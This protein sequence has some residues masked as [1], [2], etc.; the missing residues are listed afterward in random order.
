[1]NADTFITLV[2]VGIVV[3]V[4][5]LGVAVGVSSARNEHAQ[6]ARRRTAGR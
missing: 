6:L 5:V 3:F 1:M 4:L 2:F